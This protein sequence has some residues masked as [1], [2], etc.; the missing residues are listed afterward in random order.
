MIHYSI[1]S[2][3][4]HKLMEHEFKYCLLRIPLKDQSHLLKVIVCIA[5]PLTPCSDIFVEQRNGK[6]DADC[7]QYSPATLKPQLVK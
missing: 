5:L 6:T 2:C 3:G 4:C 7:T 1:Q